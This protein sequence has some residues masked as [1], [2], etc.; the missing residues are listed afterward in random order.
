MQ[1]KITQDGEGRLA[2]SFIHWAKQTPKLSHHGPFLRVPYRWLSRVHETFIGRMGKVRDSNQFIRLKKASILACEGYWPL[3][4]SFTVSLP[5]LWLCLH[6]SAHTVLSAWM[7][8]PKL[9]TQVSLSH[10]SGLCS[11]S[12]SL[13]TLGFFF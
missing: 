7:L 13:T 8:L 2:W 3:I 1:K 9:L 12:P 10:H 11:L 5:A 6:D 4:S